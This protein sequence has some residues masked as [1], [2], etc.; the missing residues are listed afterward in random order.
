MLLFNPELV[1]NT[2]VDKIYQIYGEKN[3]SNITLRAERGI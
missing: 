1:G 3:L 2:L